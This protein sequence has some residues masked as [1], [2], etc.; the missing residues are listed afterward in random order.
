MTINDLAKKTKLFLLDMDGTVY[1]GKDWISGAR[2]FLDKITAS[3]RQYAFV[4]NN[5]SRGTAQYIQKLADMG[6]A[7]EE[8]QIIISS[9]ATADYL[10]RHFPN[11]PVFALGTHQLKAELSQRG[12]A[13][14]QNDTADVA[15]VSFDTSLCYK[16][17]C[18]ICDLVRAG[19]P[20][21]ATHPDFNCPTESGFIP[22][23]GAN[24]AF[25]KASCGREPDAVIGKPQPALLEYAMSIFGTKAIETAMIGDRLYTDIGS[26]INAGVST[27]LV[28]SGETT[29]DQAAASPIKPDII[30][31]SVA[32]I[33][34]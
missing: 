6:L 7:V 19:K 17:L 20:Y 32:D 25:I 15:L 10:N 9:H 12:V 8:R 29:K 31:N 4:T 11:K 18:V 2:E 23:A 30:I 24:I 14:C 28:L 1:L 33:T 34:F 27:V 3:G 21:I 26:G 22:D 5:A 16:D 13:V